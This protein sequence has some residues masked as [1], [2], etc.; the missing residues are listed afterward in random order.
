MIKPA[1][2]LKEDQ[3]NNLFKAFS[4]ADVSTSRK[5]GGSGLGLAICQ[6]LT[7]MM[8]GEIWVESEYG[9]GSTFYFTASIDRQL[10]QKKEQMRH[11]FEVA[12]DNLK[13]SVLQT[14]C[15]CFLLTGH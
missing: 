11:A 4:Q 6:R 3:K 12:G 13:R 7:Q 10:I 1:C 15:G 2:G 9:K 8:N 14:R 5:Y